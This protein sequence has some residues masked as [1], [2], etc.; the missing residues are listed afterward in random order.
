MTGIALQ[1]NFD[2]AP[3]VSGSPLGTADPTGQRWTDLLGGWSITSGTAFAA[4]IHGSGHAVACCE[5]GDSD[6]TAEAVLVGPFGTGI[7]IGIAYRI[8][9]ANNYRFAFLYRVSGGGDYSI[10][11]GHRVAGVDSYDHASNV[12]T[13]NNNPGAGKSL[14]VVCAGTSLEV[15]YDG[16][17][18]GSTFGAADLAAGTKQGL[19]ALGSACWVDRLV[20]VGP[21]GR[22]GVVY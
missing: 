16:T 4:S 6:T 7:G 3:V 21:Q 1:D 2:R 15:W 19:I 14:K 11:S 8:I 18:Y 20:T 12:S 17:K 22:F 10:Y 5:T 13:G 9:D